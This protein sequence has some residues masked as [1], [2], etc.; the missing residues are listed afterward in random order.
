ISLLRKDSLEGKG[1]AGYPMVAFITALLFLIHP[2]QVESVVWISASKVLLYAFFFLSALVFYLRYIATNRKVFYF[3]GIDFFIL[4]LEAKEQTLIFP[5]VLE[6]INWYLRLDL[7][8]KRVISEKI[9][10]FLQSIGFIIV[11][12]NAHQTGFSYKL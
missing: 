6:L 4:Y 5:L 10:F 8:Y 12:I 11:S 2:M 1:G 9:P 3:L 7:K